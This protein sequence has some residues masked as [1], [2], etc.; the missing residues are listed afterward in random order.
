LRE[1]DWQ[2]VGLDSDMGKVEQHL[3]EGRRVVYADAE[4]PELWHRLSLDRVRAI[5]LAL[6]DGE[7]KIIASRQLRA[8]GFDGLISA[9]HVYDEERAPILAA[10]CDVTFNYFAEA[11]T[12]FAAH[13]AD[14]LG[15]ASAGASSSRDER[16]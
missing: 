6:P 14:A 9:T 5:M 8:R 2:V 11:G 10:G 4:D 16:G 15:T 7:A 12:G 3:R 13:T 1:L